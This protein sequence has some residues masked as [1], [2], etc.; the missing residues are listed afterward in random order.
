MSTVYY[1]GNKECPEAQVVR[2]NKFPDDIVP[3][4][5][6]HLNVKDAVRA[7]IVL[8]KRWEYL[9]I[10]LTNLDFGDSDLVR[11]EP[12]NKFVSI[13]N[14]NK[15]MKWVNQVLSLNVA[16]SINEFRVCFALAGYCTHVINSWVEFAISRHVKKLELDFTVNYHFLYGALYYELKHDVFIKSFPY[17]GG[18]YFLTSLCLKFV[19]INGVLLDSIL[20]RCQ[21]LEQLVVENSYRLDWVLVTNSFGRLKHLAIRNCDL[22]QSLD[23]NMAAVVSFKLHCIENAD[24]VDSNVA[25]HKLFYMQGIW[26][27]EVNFVNNDDIRRVDDLNNLLISD[28]V[29]GQNDFRFLKSLCLKSVDNSAELLNLP[30]LSQFQYLEQLILEGASDVVCMKI[31]SLLRKCNTPCC[32]Q[33][34][35]KGTQQ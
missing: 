16:P 33:Q 18:L 25:S 23:I 15:Y 27:L 30:V 32:P 26:N 3:S 22:V 21:F 7:S 2:N 29:E 1:P 31:T 10:N 12:E 19:N 11:H 13:E 35:N 24:W 4:I 20:L 17:D 9:L 34:I 6:S 8:T 14:A 5:I 28:V